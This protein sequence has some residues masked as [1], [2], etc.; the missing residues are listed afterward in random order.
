MHKNWSYR[1]D[2]KENFVAKN[3]FVVD[4]QK[5]KENTGK[6]FQHV[7]IPAIGELKSK[8]YIFDFTSKKV[9]IWE[10]TVILIACINCFQAPLEISME[11][12]VFNAAWYKVLTIFIDIFF[13]IDILVNFNTSIEISEVMIYDRRIIAV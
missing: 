2:N 6:P 1:I 10:V 11:L 7:E 13:M 8:N 12:D 5:A 3:R 9:K 4:V